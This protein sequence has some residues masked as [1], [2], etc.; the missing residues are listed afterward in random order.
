METQRMGSQL[1]ESV[2]AQRILERAAEAASSKH[3]QEVWNDP[4]GRIA[5]FASQTQI[6]F[7][8]ARNNVDEVV[9]C[10]LLDGLDEARSR[11]ASTLSISIVHLLDGGKALRVQR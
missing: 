1:Q 10:V 8:T 5:V 2:G 9:L 4:P 3:V 11:Y 7:V 6:Q